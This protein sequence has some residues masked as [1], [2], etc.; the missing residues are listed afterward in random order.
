MRAKFAHA[1]LSEKEYYLVDAL[2]VKNY[3][4][5]KY[6]FWNELFIEIGHVMAAQR[7]K[8]TWNKNDLNALWRRIKEFMKCYYHSI[9][10]WN[11]R[12]KQD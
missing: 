9:S 6:I 7:K 12:F 5:K 8:K 11:M 1:A 10:T 4:K 3:C 2:V